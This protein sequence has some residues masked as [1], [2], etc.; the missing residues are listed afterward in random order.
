MPDT[1]R[2]QPTRSRLRNQRQIYEGRHQLCRVGKKYEVAMQQHRGTNAYRIALHCRN[3]WTGSLT[4]IP[5]E[6]ERLAFS[7]IASVGLGAEIG[8]IV[9][10]RETVAISLE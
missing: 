10:G 6:S 1:G 8:D 7:C 3:E 9:S 4:E 5:D 2:Q